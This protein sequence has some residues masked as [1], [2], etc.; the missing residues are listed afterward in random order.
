MADTKL[1]HFFPSSS[2]SRQQQDIAD[3]GVDGPSSR[4]VVETLAGEWQIQCERSAVYEPL[5]QCVA[6]SYEPPHADLCRPV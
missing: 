4:E 3:H 2:H 6:A 5:Q 1:F